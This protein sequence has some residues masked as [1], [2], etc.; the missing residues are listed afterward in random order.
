MAERIVSMHAAYRSGKEVVDGFI[1]RPSAGGARNAI[2]L[3][4]GYRGLDDGQRAVTRRFAREGFVCLSPDL[5]YGRLYNTPEAC[6]LAKTSLDIPK[7]VEKICDSV[8]YLRRLPYVGNRKIA[9]LGFC[10]GGGLALYALAKSKSFAA[11]VIYY[12]S[13][14]PDPEDLRGI[15]A[16][17][18]CHYGTE[19]SNTTAAEIDM[20]RQALDRYGKKYK[21][22]MYQGAGHAFLNNPAGKIEANRKAA[23]QSVAG[24]RKWLK[25]LFS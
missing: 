23:E 8:S 19:D 7:A 4:H 13:L 2:V 16:P 15:R 5:F 14:F 1:S 20:F 17:L 6:A 11:G 24:T 21:I 9:V 12:Q 18:L 3:I 25:K 10:M 22:R